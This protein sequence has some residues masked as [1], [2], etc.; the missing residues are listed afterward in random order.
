M[1]P[2]RFLVI[3]IFASAFLSLGIYLWRVFKQEPQQKLKE[4]AQKAIENKVFCKELADKMRQAMDQELLVS[5]D[6]VGDFIK[7][8]TDEKVEDLVEE[9]T[10]Q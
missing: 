6:S 5:T 2:E 10:R 7:K 3:A 4:A 1:N 9:E 8:W